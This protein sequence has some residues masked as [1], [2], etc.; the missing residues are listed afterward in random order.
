MPYVFVEELP[1]GAEEADVVS[2][3]DF[4]SVSQSLFDANVS[5]EGLA[6]RA[7]QAEN[8]LGALRRKYANAFMKTPVPSKDDL[9]TPPD[10]GAH[11]FAELFK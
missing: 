7:I 1:E 10:T 4:E 2:R 6:D 5:I 9:G 11:S 8:D 3:E